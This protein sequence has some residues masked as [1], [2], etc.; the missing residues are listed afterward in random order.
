MDDDIRI[1]SN[2]DVE[3]HHIFDPYNEL[4]VSQILLSTRSTS[5]ST[6]TTTNTNTNIH[7]HTSFTR[8]YIYDIYNNNNN[9]VV[10]NSN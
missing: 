6:S 9:Y 8:T 1:E 3:T 5:T 2:N 10:K 7:I 4:N